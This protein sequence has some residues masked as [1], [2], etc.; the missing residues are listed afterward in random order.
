M[1]FIKKPTNTNALI[2]GAGA[3]GRGISQAGQSAFNL[4]DDKQKQGNI[5]RDHD[6]KASESK[7]KQ[8]N[9]DKKY[10]DEQATK[11]A[12]ISAYKKLHPKTTAGLNDEEIYALGSK[13]TA[14]HNDNTKMKFNDSYTDPD[15]N[16]MGVFTTG[17]KDANGQPVYKTI[18]FGKVKVNTKAGDGEATLEDL[19]RINK[20]QFRKLNKNIESFEIN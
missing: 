5:N 20:E 18:N 9:I 14:I 4:G 10:N 8:G 1:G 7:R 19:N 17:K 6:F 2:N 15:G 13:I 3:L 11:Q 12:N 16:R